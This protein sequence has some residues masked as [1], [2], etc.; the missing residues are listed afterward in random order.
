M[1]DIDDPFIRY[2]YLGFIA[3]AAVTA[4]ELAI[5]DVMQRFADEKHKALGELTRAKFSRLNGRISLNDLKRGQIVCFGRKYL[6][7][8]DK[9]L[10]EAET[11]ARTA[12]E[13]SIAS[14]YGNL[15]SWRHKFVHE[16]EPPTNAT[17]P[18]LRSAYTQGKEV[19]RC[20]D[21]A[22]RR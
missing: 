6:V 20:M 18:E 8:F 13:P 10:L 12:R 14:S 5:K 22:L 11:I 4:Y 15:V 7:K 17:Y 9:K 16:G 2:R 19:I 1:D 3:V 21:M